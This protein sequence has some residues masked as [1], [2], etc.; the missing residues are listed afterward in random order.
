MTKFEI[1]IIYEEVYDLR[2]LN[3]IIKFSNI[4]EDTFFIIEANVD[5]PSFILTNGINDFT[6]QYFNDISQQVNKFTFI[7]T[8]FIKDI[9]LCL[10][11]GFLNNYFKI[12]NYKLTLKKISGSTY[13]TDKEQ[14]FSIFN[15][16]K[17]YKE[18]LSEIKIL[19]IK[20]C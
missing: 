18:N 15:I 17:E 16:I 6:F 10:D 19:S 4:D 2:H 8:K 3:D 5:E 14:I 7:V 13:F 20:I 11:T 1:N 12:V 9:S